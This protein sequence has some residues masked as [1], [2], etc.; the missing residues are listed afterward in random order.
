MSLPTKPK[1]DP[2]PI[3]VTV[4]L[5]ETTAGRL[6]ALAQEHNLSQADVIEYLIN[7]E[8]EASEKRSKKQ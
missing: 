7:V 3:A 2:R 8:Y 1:R 4:R 5:S 6:K